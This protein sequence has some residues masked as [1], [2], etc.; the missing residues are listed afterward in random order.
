MPVSFT[1]QPSDGLSTF[2]VLRAINPHSLQ[3]G[4]DSA[5]ATQVSNMLSVW[6]QRAVEMCMVIGIARLWVKLSH[7]SLSVQGRK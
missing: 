1:A 5:A 6:P 2:D 7:G 3:S 4:M